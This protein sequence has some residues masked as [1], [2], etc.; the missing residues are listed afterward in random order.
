MKKDA[1][2]YVAG[3]RGLVGSAILRRLKGAGF[4]HIITRTRSELD[5]L[6]QDQV[7]HFFERHRPEFVF[8]A[9]ARVGGIWA[10]NTYP[11]EFIYQNLQIQNHIIHQ[12]H[13]HGAKR[14]LFLG[15]SCIY[16][17]HAAQPMVEDALMTGPLEP[18]NAPYAVAKIAGIEMCWSYNRQHNTHFIPVMPTNLYGPEDNYD[19]TS[20][21]VLPALIRKFHLAKLAGQGAWDAILADEARYGEIPVD[22]A[23]SLAAIAVSEG[24]GV[25]AAMEARAASRSKARPA[26]L[27]WGTGA[28]RREFLYV[29]DLAD[30]C[31]FL[32]SQPFKTICEAGPTPEKILFNIGTGTDVTIGDLAATIAD[33]I[34]YAGEIVWDADKPDGTPRKLLDVSRMAGLGWDARTALEEGIAK[35]YHLY[36]A[37]LDE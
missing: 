5:L 27:L 25:P 24:H 16:P 28:P 20:S 26:V 29:E 33:L 1:R 37:P 22:V 21:H 18:T 15:S 23:A 30:A 10:N 8:L 6:H 11:A 7:A 19:L 9:A 31:V 34:G 17:K 12:S 36:S 35:A 4:S 14:L 32:M 13:L 2:I 3:H